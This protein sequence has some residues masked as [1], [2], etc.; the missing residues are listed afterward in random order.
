MFIK[1]PKCD[2]WFETEIKKADMVTALCQLAPDECLWDG[3]TKRQ[4][5]ILSDK[6]HIAGIRFDK[7]K[8]VKITL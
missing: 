1:C 6:L 2:S 5:K 8:D 4:I 7:I 3:L